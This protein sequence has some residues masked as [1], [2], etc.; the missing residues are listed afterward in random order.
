MQ[1]C[2]TDSLL[3]TYYESSTYYNVHALKPS[4]FVVLPPTMGKK[5]KKA[6]AGKP[7]KLTPKDTSKRLNALTKN[8]EE[9]LEGADLFAPL[10]PTEDCAICFVPLSRAERQTFYQACCGKDICKACYKENEASINKQN[11]KNADNKNKKPIP[12][13]CPFCRE[14]EP[15]GMEYTGRL[16]ARCLQNDPIAFTLLGHRYQM[17]ECGSPKDDLKALDCFI[18]AVELGSADACTNIGVIYDKGI[19]VAVDK[20]RAALFERAGALR[21][22]TSLRVTT[23]AFPNSGLATSNLESATG[24]LQLKLG[25]NPPSTI[26]EKFTMPV[27][28]YP[29]INSS[30]RKKWTRSI[31]LAMTLKRRSRARKERSICRYLLDSFLT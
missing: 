30:A 8:L 13:T 27:V 14:P 16:Q 7:K 3:T 9:E 1:S 26:S 21:G 12:W 25:T 23:S 5:G 17:G 20:E 24:R 31:A 19:G 15:T 6:Q 22:D 2:C 18:R 28:K 11:E 10:P 29:E 4:V